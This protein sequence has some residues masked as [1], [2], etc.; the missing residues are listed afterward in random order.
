MCVC[1]PD[2]LPV[3]SAVFTWELSCVIPDYVYLC[4]ACLGGYVC[5]SVCARHCV[6]RHVVATSQFNLSPTSN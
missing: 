4:I 1:V 2:L 6:E 5:A 3:Y